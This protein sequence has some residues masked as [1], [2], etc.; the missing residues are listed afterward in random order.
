MQINKEPKVNDS[1]ALVKL[2]HMR[3]TPHTADQYSLP[4]HGS[5]QN[6]TDKGT[7]RRE[8]SKWRTLRD[9][10]FSHILEG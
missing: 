3:E 6:L 10:T 2:N 5:S 8:G 4:F 9:F 1:L 7:I